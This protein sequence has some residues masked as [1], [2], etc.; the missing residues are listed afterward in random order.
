MYDKKDYDKKVR[1]IRILMSDWLLIKSLAQEA[2]VSMH[3]ALHQRIGN[4]ASRSES[5]RRYRR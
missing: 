1:P 3:E 2:G 4:K 5:I